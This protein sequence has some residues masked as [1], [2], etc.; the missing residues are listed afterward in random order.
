VKTT[1]KE[2][3]S[4][5]RSLTVLAAGTPATDFSMNCVLKSMRARGVAARKLP[6]AWSDCSWTVEVSKAPQMAKE[7]DS[8]LYLLLLRS[9]LQTRRRYLL[10]ARGD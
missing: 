10:P 3:K 4:N 8:F 6:V 1:A 7:F 2:S 9:V 5:N